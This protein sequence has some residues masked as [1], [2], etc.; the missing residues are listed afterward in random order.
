MVLSHWPVIWGNN[1][2]SQGQVRS[3]FG[4]SYQT[5]M[6]R[7]GYTRSHHLCRSQ[8]GRQGSGAFSGHPNSPS[9]LHRQLAVWSGS[10]GPSCVSL[11]V[12][13]TAPSG[14]DAGG[15]MVLPLWLTGFLQV[16]FLEV[17]QGR[18]HKLT[19]QIPAPWP[20]H[21]HR[22]LGT[23]PPWIKRAGLPGMN[24]RCVATDISAQ[25]LLHSFQQNKSR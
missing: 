20:H 6:Q 10:W 1:K 21:L 22:K 8:G 9:C 5:C 16:I 11:P 2:T 7:S 4:H 19:G 12:P 24:R 3:A 23:L 17:P 18:R 25:P 14:G 13:S 15:A